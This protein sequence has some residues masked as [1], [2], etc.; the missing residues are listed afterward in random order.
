MSGAKRLLDGFGESPRRAAALIVAVVLLSATTFVFAAS[1]DPFQATSF[2]SLHKTAF[3]T[4]VA[5]RRARRGKLSPFMRSRCVVATHER[6]HREHHRKSHRSCV[7]KRSRKGAGS[8]PSSPPSGTVP[9]GAQTPRSGGTPP[10]EPTS[11]SE[12]STP[13]R[14]FSPASFWNEPPP[15]DA[16]LAPNS[17]AMMGAFSEKIVKE[18]EAGTPT[19]IN[20]TSYSVP[21]Y[22]VSADEPMVRV[23]LD[24][25]Q[26][27][28]ALQAAWDA[29][30][31]PADAQPAA[32]TDKHLV[33]WQPST[34]RLWEF[35]RLEQTPTG[36][37]AAW[38]GAIRNVSSNSG[39]YGRKAWPGASPY[40]GASASSLSV[41]GGLITLEDLELGQINHALAIGIPEVRA[42]AYASPAQRTDGTSTSS[43]SLPEG[44]RMR[45]DPSLDLA[46]LRLPRL[47]L[48]MA[49]AAQRYGIVVRDHT[50]NISFYAQDPTPTGTNPYAGPNGYFEGKTPAQLLASF[51]WSHLQL[52]K[53]ELHN[54]F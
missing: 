50:A 29:V 28:P 22:T 44:A 5:K 16:S 24:H 37:Q 9:S 38:G 33:V 32:G 19:A 35:W 46:A 53:T 20:T 36:W 31:L 13:F 23:T 18:E 52:L 4:R 49:E 26:P 42:G 51:P 30:P 12:P 27:P 40:W 21:I 7:V 47:T 39:V 17:A 15:A 14:F 54:S 1:A 11:P 8:V 43:L 41:A 45:L 34:N 10:A 6:K 48:M 3:A 2:S 25:A